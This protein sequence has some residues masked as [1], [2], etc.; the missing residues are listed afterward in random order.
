MEGKISLR[1]TGLSKYYGGFA[2]LDKAD[3]NFA[4]GEVHALLGENGAGKSTLCKMLSGA[5]TPTE[6]T[7]TIGEK[8]FKELTPQSAKEN[9]IGMIYQEFNLVP[10]L[11]I[12]ENLFLGK[13]LRKGVNI[14]RK[15]MIRQTEKIF[16]RFHIS[17]DPR[18]RVSQLSVAYC[19][20][21]EIAKALLENVKI[22]I[23]DEPTAPLTQREIEVLFEQIR[24]LKAS[25]VTIIYISHRMNELFQIAD[26]ITVMR[27][28]KI[29]KT[30]KR[31]EAKQEELI[32]LMVGRQLDM[33]YPKKEE[34]KAGK[35][36]LAVEGL[37]NRKLHDITFEL[38]EGEVLGIAGLVGAGRTELLKALFGID[39]IKGGTIKI[40]GKEVKIRSPKDA[41]KKGI[42]FIPED[43]KREGLQM[44]MPI[45][46]NVSLVQIQ[47]L[48]KCT[49]IN[50]KKEKKLVSRVSEMLRV[51]MGSME[52][53]PGSLSG[54]NQQKVVLSRCIASDADII[55]MDEP[56]RGVDVGAKQEIYGIINDMR[57]KGK[58][59]IMVSS[60][61]PE[62][63]GV[64]DRILVLYE[65]KV[66][67]E[68]L[69]D[70]SQEEV[71]QAAL[72]GHSERKGEAV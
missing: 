11:T 9:G 19:Q 65:G 62:I 30:L 60:E 37:G 41:M 40:H 69:S 17:I 54:G 48:S 56:T 43:R 66:Q 14:D 18:S 10:E 29:I 20:L 58:G 50:K 33:T 12:Y 45:R 34:I 57:S 47:E 4:E 55:L 52:E 26:T 24:K 22:L 5:V 2:A 16:A 3:I 31:S 1:I 59:I 46:A 27:D 44:D 25:G 51:K 23:M 68:F 70:V 49:T 36:L 53:L 28:A 72:G 64:S 67:K 61:L 21:V 15:E 38:R 7:I 13:E 39:R 63:L 32:R 35:S 71:L 8:E 6:G 42:S